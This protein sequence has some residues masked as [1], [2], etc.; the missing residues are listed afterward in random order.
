MKLVGSCRPSTPARRS[1]TSDGSDAAPRS[2]RSISAGSSRSIARPSSCDVMP[3]VS[4]AWRSS[5]PA[6][7]AAACCFGSRAFALARF[8]DSSAALPATPSMVSAQRRISRASCSTG[9]A[10]ARIGGMVGG[11]SV[12]RGAAFFVE[13]RLRVVGIC[14][15][16]VESCRL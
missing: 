2:A 9:A 7:S 6:L 8:S 15:L 10:P 12:V 13:L 1:T 11:A 4:R 16:Q 3:A 5:E 14:V